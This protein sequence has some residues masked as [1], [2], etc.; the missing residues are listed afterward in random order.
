M[1]NLLVTQKVALAPLT[2]LKVGGEA[3]YFTTVASDEEI[4]EAVRFARQNALPLFVLGGGSN[5]LV[6]DKEYP[7]L[8]L[9]MNSRGYTFEIVSTTHVRVEVEAGE[10]LD[11]FIAETIARGWWGLEN[12]SHIPGTVGATPVQNVGA[13]GVEVADYILSVTVYNTATSTIEIL[14]N[15][16]CLFGYRDSFFKTEEGRHYII[17]R[18]TFLLLQNPLPR[19]GYA[20]LERQFSGSNIPTQQEIRLA[21]ISIRSAKFPDWSTVGTAGSFFKNPIVPLHVAE[22]LRVKY[23]NMPTY[24]VDA[25]TVKLP[26]GYILDKI[27]NLKGVRK[28][29]VRLYEEQALVLVADSGA[30]ATEIETFAGEVQQK[31]F[32]DTNI[33]I[34]LEVTKI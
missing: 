13:Y 32:A 8:V 22:T 31:V 33:F 9:H 2:T 20:D 16:E 23:P 5:V 21:I 34:S 4:K 10:T 27:C 25:G 24:S 11:S 12:L 1:S 29:H 14:S 17:L 18:V 15:E 3:R 6:G 19:L 30:T 28:N 7:G 26:L